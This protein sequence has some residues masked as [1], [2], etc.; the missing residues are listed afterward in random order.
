MIEITKADGTVE[1]FDGTKLE[2]SLRRAGASSK[3]ASEIRS[4]VEG[5]LVPKMTT[6]DIY[7]RA[8]SLLRKDER[9]TAVRYSLR[10]AIF[11]LGPTGHPFEDFVAELFRKEG[12]T[13][14]WR[15]VIP[16]KCVMHEVDVYAT[17]GNEHLAAELKYHNDPNYKTDVKV[18]LYVKARFD[19]IW[20]CDPSVTNVCPVD[21]GFLITNTKFTE[22]AIQYAKC[23]GIELIGWSYPSEGNLYDRVLSAGIYPVTSLVSLQKSEKRLLIDRGIVTSNQLAEKR[24]VLRQIAIPADRIGKIIAEIETLANPVG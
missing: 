14:E 5:T 21:R 8:F 15:K 19:D 20:Q 22:T 7:R 12:W 23:A 18:A 17:K 2:A 10:R 4:A 6:H 24:D 9:S 11:E 16:G 3:I 1:V 13:V